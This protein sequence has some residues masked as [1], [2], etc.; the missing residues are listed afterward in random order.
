MS[1]QCF[2]V[3]FNLGV[4]QSKIDNVVVRKVAEVRC[5]VVEYVDVQ[6]IVAVANEASAGTAFNTSKRFPGGSADSLSPAG[7]VEHPPS[8]HGFESCRV[9]VTVSLHLLSSQQ[10]SHSIFS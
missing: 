10:L 2:Q 3:Y 1:T 9:L 7:A 5:K 8:G 6:R 4:L